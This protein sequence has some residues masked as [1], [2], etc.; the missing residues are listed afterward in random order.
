MVSCVRFTSGAAPTLDPVT[1][2]V[3]ASKNGVR[4]EQLQQGEVLF[5]ERRTPSPCFALN[6]PSLPDPKLPWQAGCWIRTPSGCPAQK[7]CCSK[8]WR[9]ERRGSQSFA[10][11]QAR[12]A[13]YDSWCGAQDSMFHFVERPAMRYFQFVPTKLRSGTMFQIA[14]LRFRYRG[15]DVALT[16]ATASADFRP[17]F[18]EDRSRQSAD[19]VVDNKLN[20]KMCCDRVTIS[21][22]FHEAVHVDE[23]AFAT[24]D[25]APERDPVKWELRGSTTGA[26]WETLHSQKT[27]YPTTRDRYTWSDWFSF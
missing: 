12:R 19:K 22:E 3:E 13:A 4:W 20:T 5:Q 14:E 6:S 9:E 18:A 11:C 10:A 25:D 27:S 16:A 23:F 1:W 24:A 8:D 21:L 7:K 15:Q 26:R 17:A 2:V